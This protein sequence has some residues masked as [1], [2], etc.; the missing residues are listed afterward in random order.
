MTP[1]PG[2]SS[3]PPTGQPAAVGN[4]PAPAGYP[5][6]GAAGYPVPGQ[7]AYG[8]PPG[9]P[10]PIAPKKKKKWP[11]IAGG[12]AVLVLIACFN[13]LPGGDTSDTAATGTDKAQ[14]AGATEKKT[15]KPAGETAAEPEPEKTTTEAST[16]IGDPVKDGKF[17]FT[18][19]KVACGKKSVG[20][21]LL[22]QKAQGQFCLITLKVKNIGDEAQMF[23]G[24]NQ[25]A[26]DAKGTEYSNDT[27]AEIY[28]NSEAQTFLNEINPGNSVTGKLVFDVPKSTKL[29]RMEL[30]DSIFSGGVEINLK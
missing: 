9:Y 8:P 14:V 23:A 30:H 22:N 28:A 26:F 11:W 5:P 4:Q 20:S 3:T 12:A 10:Q 21:S 29:T 13:A 2:Q 19:T 1:G 17:Q 16:G 6:P 25:K 18:V 27:S 15:S 24:S 7:P